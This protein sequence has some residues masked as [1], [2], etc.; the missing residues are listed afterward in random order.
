[1]TRS[2]SH[3]LAVLAFLL[4]LG[5]GC[6]TTASQSSEPPEVQVQRQQER[7]VIGVSLAVSGLVQSGDISRRDVGRI[8]SGLR[9]LAAGSTAVLASELAS[10]LELEPL[11]MVALQLALLELE[12]QLER[13]GLLDGELGLSDQGRQ[14]LIEVADALDRIAAQPA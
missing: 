5:G 10:E 7:V 2:A 6:A 12:G 1:M 3:R 13:W 4:P 8:S 9:G 11:E 14:L